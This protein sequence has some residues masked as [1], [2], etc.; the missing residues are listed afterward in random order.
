MI[1]W[2]IDRVDPDLKGQ[3]VA[4]AGGE[5]G[6]YAAFAEVEGAAHSGEFVPCTGV[7][8][9]GGFEGLAFHAAHGGVGWLFVQLINIHADAAVGLCVGLHS[10]AAGGVAKDGFHAEA[11]AAGEYAEA[12]GLGFADQDDGLGTFA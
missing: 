12:V 3:G 10:E 4:F 6:G 11:G 5:T 9:D 2:S 8:G 1:G 7:D